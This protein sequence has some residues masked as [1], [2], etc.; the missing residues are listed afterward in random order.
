MIIPFRWAHR[1]TW[2]V[3]ALAPLA[4]LAQA[5]DEPATTTSAPYLFDV[6][7]SRPA[8]PADR[9]DLIER[10][11]H[12][13]G[14]EAEALNAVR[15]GVHQWNETGLYVLLARVAELPA[16]EPDGFAALDRPAY[17]NLL[18]RP[19]RYR[20]QAMRLTFR[21]FRVQKMTA[22]NGLL[23]HT[24]F[25]PK[26]R[27]VWRM[28]GTFGQ[29]LDP[30]RPVAVFSV[31]DPSALL[32]RPDETA[33]DEM[34]YKRGRPVEA[35]CVFYKVYTDREADP[36]HN[37][38]KYPLALAWQL[39]RPVPGGSAAADPRVWV[40]AVL[41]LAG[42]M[43]YFFLRRQAKRFGRR[44]AEYR[45]R[46]EEARAPE[47][48]VPDEPEDDADVDPLLKAAAEDY[49][50]QARRQGATDRKEPEKP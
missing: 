11:L 44:R 30:D 47:V 40:P 3:V 14:A 25:W 37:T 8:E 39:A 46:R 1:A 45:A 13:T 38:R 43:L 20:A 22:D 34:R 15:D 6:A 16:L 50:Q 12:F 23:T 28:F 31:A 24:P 48:A 21:V 33:T 41:I 19:Q 7:A 4:P 32:G 49:H 42:G 17:E 26:E 35:A 27:P 36:P 10:K 9:G 18:R 29:R 5:A 2:L